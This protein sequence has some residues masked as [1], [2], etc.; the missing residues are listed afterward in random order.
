MGRWGAA[1]RV[2][3][4]VATGDLQGLSWCW[5]SSGVC[6]VGCCGVCWSGVCG[7]EPPDDGD[8][9][10]D[11]GDDGGGESDGEGGFS[12][13]RFGGSFEGFGLWSVG[14][15][16]LDQSLELSGPESACFAEIVV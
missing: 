5:W 15:F 7:G 9:E 6:R 16:E 1:K 10:Y 4:G 8:N 2:D 14:E 13:E 11:G 3:N 12:G